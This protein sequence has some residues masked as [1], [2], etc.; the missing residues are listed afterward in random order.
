MPSSTPLRRELLLALGVLFAGATLLA[1]LGLLVLLPLFTSQGEALAFV[2]VLLSADLIILFIFTSHLL[3]SR[4]LAPVAALVSDVQQI[5]DGV[6]DQRVRDMPNIEL[7]AIAESVNAMADRLMHERG[8]LAQNVASLERTNEEL[9]IARD[10]I[11]QAARLASVGTLAAGIAHEVGNPLGAILVYVDLARNR[12]PRPSEEAELL[13]SVRREAERIDAIVR[14]LL[15]FARPSESEPHPSQVGPVLHRVRDLLESQ[16]K[17]TEVSDTWE[18]DQAKVPRVLMAPHR[19]E[20]VMVNVL[21]NALQALSGREDPHI[22]VT[23][24]GEAGAMTRV[25]GRRDDDPPGVNYLHRRRVSGDR[26]REGPDP[27]FT[28]PGL[29]VIEVVDNGPGI[30]D[31][32]LEQIFDPFFTTKDPGEGTGLGLAICARLVE[33]MGGRIAATNA[34]NGGAVFTIRLPGLTTSESSSAP[35]A[36]TEIEELKPDRTLGGHA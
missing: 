17:L 7:H 9:I 16:G 18:V 36:T 25:S 12:A 13:D 2:V 19:L 4:L 11:I 15:D 6:V 30:A 32:N 34:R 33:G 14:G 5:A 1:A 24:E 20:Q 28:A 27:L 22:R 8:L 35:D 3:R 21:L 26:N 29:A 31:E 10:Q 23:L